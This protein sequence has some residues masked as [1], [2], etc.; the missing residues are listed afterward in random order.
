MTNPKAPGAAIK[1]APPD[2][3]RTPKSEQRNRMP[4]KVAA[5]SALAKH[6]RLHSS[7]Y[8]NLVKQLAKEHGVKVAAVPVAMKNP[9]RLTSP[10]AAEKV[11]RD[12]GI[13]TRTGKLSSRFK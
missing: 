12:A 10:K 6:A 11:L 3:A 4:S 1:A 5:A 9:Y 13:L 7:S 8:A 2:Q